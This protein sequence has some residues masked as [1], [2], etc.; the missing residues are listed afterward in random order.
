MRHPRWIKWLRDSLPDTD[1]VI[2]LALEIGPQ[3]NIDHHAR[4][5]IFWFR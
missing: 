4:F 2:F 1:G 3:V 5:L